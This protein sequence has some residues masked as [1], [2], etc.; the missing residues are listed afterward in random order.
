[1]TFDEIQE[2]IEGMLTVQREL[3]ESQLKLVEKQADHDENLTRIETNMNQLQN[4]INDLAQLA[5][6][7]DNALLNRIEAIEKRVFPEQN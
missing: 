4:L 3:Q 7:S 6:T 2:T 1:M 5:L